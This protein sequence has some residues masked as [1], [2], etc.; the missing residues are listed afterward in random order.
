MRFPE[1]AMLMKDE[2]AK[3]IV[4]PGAFNTTTGPAHWELLQ[5]ARAVD[6]QLY[7]ATV[8]PAR[9]PDSAYISFKP[10]FCFIS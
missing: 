5:R 4:Y 7:V 6:N 2:G 10:F 8:S 9:C 1:L 3:L